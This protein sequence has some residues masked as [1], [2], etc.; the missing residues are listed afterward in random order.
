ML[1][2]YFDTPFTVYSFIKSSL[3]FLYGIS[4]RQED[5]RQQILLIWFFSTRACGSS[6][7]VSL[8]KRPRGPR[9]IEQ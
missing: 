4:G 7:Q 2:T 5:G 1:T 3:T 8:A 9:F 6:H